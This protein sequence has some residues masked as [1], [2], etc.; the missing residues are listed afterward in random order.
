MSLCLGTPYQ[1][2]PFELCWLHLYTAV[3]LF[4]PVIWSKACLC[5]DDWTAPPPHML[6]CTDSNVLLTATPETQHSLEE[7]IWG[8]EQFWHFNSFLKILFTY[9]YVC[10]YT[11]ALFRHTRR[12]CTG[13]LYRWLWATMWLLGIDLRTSGRAVSAPNHWAISTILNWD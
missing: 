4:R 12:V 13:S 3:Q 6:V 8:M 2:K 5:T 10:E 7:Y 11:V 1:Q 9:F